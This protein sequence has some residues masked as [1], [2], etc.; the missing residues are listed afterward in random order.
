LRKLQPS[1]GAIWQTDQSRIEKKRKWKKKKKQANYVAEIRAANNRSA[2]SLARDYM[3]CLESKA[4]NET[5]RA[6]ID[7]LHASIV[8]RPKRELRNNPK[9]QNG[10]N[11]FHEG[12]SFD[13]LAINYLH[14]ICARSRDKCLL[15]VRRHDITLQATRM[16]AF[17][18]SEPVL[19][20]AHRIFDVPWQSG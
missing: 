8:D 13:R 11:R 7:N 9:L 2:R 19:R 3:E 17:S 10:R 5:K 18:H 20:H 15:R 1:D 16:S 12:R 6:R 14:R 4:E